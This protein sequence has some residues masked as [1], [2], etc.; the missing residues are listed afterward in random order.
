[1]VKLVEFDSLTQIYN[2]S[3]AFEKIEYML[4]QG[5]S[6]VCFAVIDIDNFKQFND[7]YGH[8]N[9]DEVL[10]TTAFLLKSYF[11]EAIIGRFGGDE[12]IVFIRDYKKPDITCEFE[13]LT[14]NAYLNVG[15][16]EKIKIS[17]SIGIVC[18][19]NVLTITELFSEAD[20]IMYDAKKNG[21]NCIIC[22]NI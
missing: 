3:A 5:Y 8:I 14:N 17:Y 11:P 12:F 16:E 1:M 20:S 22:K 10:N 4:N 15:N 2:K 13:S 18:T 9:G 7:L 19:E 6:N 21:K